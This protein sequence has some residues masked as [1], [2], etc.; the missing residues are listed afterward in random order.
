MSQMK[1][2]VETMQVTAGKSP[3]SSRSRSSRCSTNCAATSKQWGAAGRGA[4]AVAFQSVMNS[5]DTSANKLQLALGSIG[6]AIKSS[7]TAYGAA[8]DDNTRSVTAAGGSL[9][10]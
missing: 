8:D 4:A 6:D 2:T 7:G 9:N 10:L 3:T 1:T 5:W